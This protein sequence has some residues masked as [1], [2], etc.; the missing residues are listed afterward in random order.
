L[1]RKRKDGEGM[2]GDGGRRKMEESEFL[3]MT[4]F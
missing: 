3:K 2:V 1:E 4:N